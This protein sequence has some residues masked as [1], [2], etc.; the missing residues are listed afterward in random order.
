MGPL[1]LLL[2]AALLLAQAAPLGA[3][4]HC[5]RLEY[6][7]PDY[8]CCG[9][10]LQRFGPPP[11][12]GEERGQGYAYVGAEPGGDKEQGKGRSLWVIACEA[13]FGIGAAGLTQITRCGAQLVMEGLV[14]VTSGSRRRG[15]AC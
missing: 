5:G 1:C 3:S 2:T 9:S 10:C 14:Q 11:C 13:C 12:P 4:Q 8:R 6:L 7:N 15:V